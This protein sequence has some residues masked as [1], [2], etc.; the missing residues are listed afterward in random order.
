MKQHTATCLAAAVASVALC[1]MLA[2]AAYSD[3]TA[4]GRVGEAAAGAGLVQDW[5][6][7]WVS[8]T[9]GNNG[10]K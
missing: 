7:H 4:K 1:A 3:F 2:V 6:G 5:R 8:P 10:Q 9:G